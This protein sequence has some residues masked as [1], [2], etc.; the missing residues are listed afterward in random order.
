MA[1][2]PAKQDS[3]SQMPQIAVSRIQS[4]IETLNYI[5]DRGYLMFKLVAD[6]S[7]YIMSTICWICVE[8]TLNANQQFDL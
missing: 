2:R 1:R 5:S 6:L 7:A 4:N 8:F 3:A